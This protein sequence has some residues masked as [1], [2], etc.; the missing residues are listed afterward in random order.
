MCEIGADSGR[1]AMATSTANKDEEVSPW[2]S[3]EEWGE[4]TV[5]NFKKHVV[6]ESVEEEAQERPG[7]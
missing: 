2:T 5:D 6:S 4:Q 7:D 3:K 1:V